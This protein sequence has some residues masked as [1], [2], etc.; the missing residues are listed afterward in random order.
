MTALGK[1]L[2]LAL[3]ASQLATA[4]KA[5]VR[6]ESMPVHVSMDP[7]SAIISTLPKGAVVA[8]DLIMLGNGIR[9]C[10]IT[11]GAE[12]EIAG[13]VNCAQLDR[14]AAGQQRPEFR[15]GAPGATIDELLRLS[16]IEEMLVRIA[17]P[18]T[19]GKALRDSGGKESPQLDQLAAV[20]QG[21]LRPERFLEAVRQKLRKDYSQERLDDVLAFC[22]SDLA[23]KTSALEVRAVSPE[24]AQGFRQYLDQMQREPPPPERLALVRRLDSVT[25]TWDLQMEIATGVLRA[26][27]ETQDPNLPPEKKLTD[28][29]LTQLTAALRGMRPELKNLTYARMLHIYEPLPAVEL[30]RYVRFWETPNGRWYRNLLYQGMMEGAR[31][32]MRELV[33]GISIMAPRRT[34]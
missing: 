13:Y 7:G 11:A 9:W 15:Q 1:L 14:G 33:R 34:P 28:A 27:A 4:Q 24:S 20:L 29:K 31:D 3:S 10:S 30:E 8:I 12:Q 23:R 2:I 18:A 25:D 6:V 17:D 16:G 21:A 22:R 32:A 26:V 5:V 19:L